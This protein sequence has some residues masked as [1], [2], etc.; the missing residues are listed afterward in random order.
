MCVCVCVCVRVAS[1]S[2]NQ[3]LVSAFDVTEEL[4]KF[5]AKTTTSRLYLLSINNEQTANSRPII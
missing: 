3:C 2:R 4:I 5:V 1:R